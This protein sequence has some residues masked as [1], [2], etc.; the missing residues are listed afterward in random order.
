MILVKMLDVRKK[1]EDKERKRV[2]VKLEK[3][4]KQERRLEQRKKDI[5]VLTELKRP[6][7]DMELNGMFMQILFC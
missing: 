2:E 4:A 3:I 5:E 6:T 7:E 1:M